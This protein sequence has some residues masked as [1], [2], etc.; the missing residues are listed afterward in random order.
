[1]T[2]AG[3]APAPAV[4][5]TYLEDVTVGECVE[6]PGITVTAAHVGLYQGLTGDL[7]ARPGTVPDLL[8]LCLSTGLGWRV[9]HAPLAVLAFLGIEWHVVRC[10]EVGDTLCSRS[11]TVAKRVLRDGGVVVR[12]QQIIDQRGQVVQHGKFTFLVA[13]RSA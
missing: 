2:A 5:Q 7:A 1:M 6:T 11:R 3:S 9:P 12:E 4:A 8:P 13:K 10:A